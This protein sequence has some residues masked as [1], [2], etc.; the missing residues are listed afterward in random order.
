M[1]AVKP[2]TP[3]MPRFDTVNVPPLSSG[4]RI[5]A[6]AHLAGEVARLPGDVAQRAPVGVEDGRH[7]QR[8]LPRDGDAHVHAAYSSNLP[9]R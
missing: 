5:V 3:Y 9:S 1:T 2:V 6:V 8:V 7:D 4:G